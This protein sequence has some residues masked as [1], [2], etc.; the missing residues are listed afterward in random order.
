ML[1]AASRCKARNQ[2]SGDHDL[3][4]S[5]KFNQL[6]HPGALGTASKGLPS[7]SLNLGSLDI[8]GSDTTWL[9]G[10]G[11]C[12][13]HYRMFSRV[14]GLYLL[15]AGS[16]RPPPLVGQPGM[17]P[18]TASGG[19]NHPQLRTAALLTELTPN[20]LHTNL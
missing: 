7:E 4:Q 15:D 11:A 1:T 3:S 8:W 10:E 20:N 13:T 12:P 18:D 5:G 9:W 2:E 17:S 19:Q 16:T 14:H 6:S